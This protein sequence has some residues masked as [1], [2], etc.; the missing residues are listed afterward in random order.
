MGL[1]LATTAGLVVWLVLWSIGAKAIDAFLIT[2]LVV[3][4]GCL[5]RILM[6]HMPGNRTR[7]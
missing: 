4:V 7:S 1:V 2:T 6:P 3:L 5:A